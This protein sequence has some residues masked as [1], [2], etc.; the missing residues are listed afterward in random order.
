M[1]ANL[2]RY[3]LPRVLGLNNLAWTRKLHGLTVSE[4]YDDIP[5]Q[6]EEGSGREHHRLALCVCVCT[7]AFVESLYFVEKDKKCR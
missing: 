5:R 7:R 1:R 6:S 2:R 3:T 4:S